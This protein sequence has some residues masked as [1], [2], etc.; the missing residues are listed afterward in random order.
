MGGFFVGKIS[1]RHIIYDQSVPGIEDTELK[2]PV[3]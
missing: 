2:W 3:S 1:L